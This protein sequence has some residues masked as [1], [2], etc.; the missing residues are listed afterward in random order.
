[1]EVLD[2]KYAYQNEFFFTVEHPFSPLCPPALG[3][4]AFVFNTC[5]YLSRENEAK[6]VGSK[7][8]IAAR[9]EADTKVKLEAM[10]RSVEANRAKVSD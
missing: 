8:D 6:H 4:D 1:M 2:Y 10:N 7:E 5:T 3:V 9:I